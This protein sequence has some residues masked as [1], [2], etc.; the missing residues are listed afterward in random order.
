MTNRVREHLR[1]PRQIGQPPQPA[2][3]S[4]TSPDAF[5][6][7]MRQIETL[8]QEHPVTGIGAAFCIGILLG[9]FSKRK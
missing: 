2:F 7:R 6:R 5:A 4:C 8:V 9:W 1:V 3:R